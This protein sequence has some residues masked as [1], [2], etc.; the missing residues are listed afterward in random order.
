MRVLLKSISVLTFVLF[1]WFGL[2]L[3]GLPKFADIDTEYP[4]M[5]VVSQEGF[6]GAGVHNFML[7]V[8]VMIATFAIV[9][10]SYYLWHKANELKTE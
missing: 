8:S 1:L 7:F 6:W 5:T 2:Y 4:S 9:I 10:T 3:M